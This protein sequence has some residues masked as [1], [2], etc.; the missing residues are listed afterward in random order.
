MRCPPWPRLWRSMHR[1]SLPSARAHTHMHTHTHKHMHADQS[2][3]RSHFASGGRQSAG[4]RR[5]RCVLHVAALGA[6]GTAVRGHAARGTLGCQIGNRSATAPRRRLER[7]RRVAWHHACRPWPVSPCCCRR[8]RCRVGGAPPS[9][10]CPL[11]LLLLLMRRRLL[12]LSLILLPR[13]LLLRRIG[14]LL[15]RIVLSVLVL[16]RVR[17]GHALA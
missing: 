12:R 3:V 16:V 1:R 8:R 9:L 4:G 17:V 7:L 5:G 13:H 11:L 2:L 14:L 6:C 10:H 15:R